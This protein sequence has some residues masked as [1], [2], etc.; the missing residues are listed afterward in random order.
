M[1]KRLARAGSS[2]CRAF[3]CVLLRAQVALVVEAFLTHAALVVFPV[4]WGVGGD[5]ILRGRIVVRRG[6]GRS[7]RG[8]RNGSGR[9]RRWS[10]L[11]RRTAVALGM[12]RGTPQRWMSHDRCLRAKPRRLAA[13]ASTQSRSDDI[14]LP[15]NHA[16]HL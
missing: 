16:S 8:G 13:A 15:V 11:V 9:S 6:R 4:R 2:G 10:A 14:E 1:W 7:G 3:L 5:A 12:A